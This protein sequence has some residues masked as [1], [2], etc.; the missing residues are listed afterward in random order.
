MDTVNV[1]EIVTDGTKS[2]DRVR[3]FGEVFTPVN[4]VKDMCDLVDNAIAKEDNITPKAILAK[5]W[6]EPSCGTGNFLVEILERKV[7]LALSIS[8]NKPEMKPI[9]EEC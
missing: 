2:K 1:N 6:L 8:E 7:K 4:I 3:D 5:T 9:Y